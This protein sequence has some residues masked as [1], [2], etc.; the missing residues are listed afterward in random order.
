MDNKNVGYI[1]GKQYMA[2]VEKDG[3][4]YRIRF[5]ASDGKRKTIRLSQFKKKQVESVCRH[6][7]ELCASVDSG[8]PIDRQTSLWLSDIGERLHN[9]LARAGLIEQRAASCLQAFLE[10]YAATRSEVKP[11]T[12]KKWR[13]TITHLITFFGAS[14]E[15]RTISEGRAD[16]FRSYLYSQGLAENTVRRCCGIAKQFMRAAQR[17]G[18]VDF[19]AFADQI[20]AVRGNPERFYFLTGK[21]AEKVLEAC[22]DLQWRMIFALCRFGGLRCPSEVLA[23]R[24]QDIDWGQEQFTVRSSKTEHLE[25]KATRIVPL[26]P[27]LRDVLGEGFSNAEE[28]GTYVITRYRDA[29][30]NLR[31]TFRKIIERAGLQPW[32]KL[33]QNLRST[34]ETELANEFPLQAV[35]AWM[36]NSQLVAAKHYLQVTDQ[37]F[38]AAKRFRVGHEVGQK[39]SESTRTEGP[40]TQKA[41][42][43]SSDFRGPADEF[44]VLQSAGV[45]DEGLEPPTF[46][47]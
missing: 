28:G 27:E 31:T 25:G 34:R 35:T 9:K 30:Q 21:D 38:S 43:K 22:P 2:S 33:F 18:L 13:T 24:W 5:I 44:S 6:V 3:K 19:N 40:P 4:G 14:C 16:E 10:A 11:S 36:G 37:H 26:F 12:Q 8:Q 7:E 23:L 39:A 45:G 17:R 46:S 20:A 41:Q 15:L 47:V 29:K 1:R 32:P 42:R